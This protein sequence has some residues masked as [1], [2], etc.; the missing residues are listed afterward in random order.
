MPTADGTA[1]T[2]GSRVDEGLGAYSLGGAHRRG[3]HADERG[4]VRPEGEESVQG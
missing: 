4:G 1:E 2:A 3:D